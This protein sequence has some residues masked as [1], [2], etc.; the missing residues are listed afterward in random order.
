MILAAIFVKDVK[1][2][3]KSFCCFLKLL[4][5]FGGFLSFLFVSASVVYTFVRWF[6]WSFLRGYFSR[7][8]IN[9]FFSLKIILPNKYF[10]CL[11]TGR[12]KFASFLSQKFSCRFHS[13]LLGCFLK[14]E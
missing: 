10:V 14:Y 4:F 8:N 1:M 13:C 2:S 11:F 7:K 3:Q 9:L 5:L 6:D 12:R